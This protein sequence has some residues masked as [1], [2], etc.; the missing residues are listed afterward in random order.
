[1]AVKRFSGSF[2][3]R[4]D[5][6]DNI[7]P[8]N[9]VVTPSGGI[10]VPAGEFKP[11]NWLPVAWQGTASQ[12]YFVI[13]SGKV[14]SLTSQGEVVPSGIRLKAEGLTGGSDTTSTLI[15]YTANDVTA[16]TV[17][18]RTGE[19]VS[20]A[21]AVTLGE[22]ATGLIER[23]LVTA[24]RAK[25]LATT[26]DWV[27]TTEADCINVVK[28]YISDPVGVA[29]YDVYHWAG[30]AYDAE[31]GLNFTNYQKQH[32]VQFFTQA[33]MQM[34]V[35]GLTQR[36]SIDLSGATAYTASAL[37]GT[38]FPTNSG[39]TVLW[40]T[41]T[42][43]NALERY[44]DSSKP[45][46][47]VAAG[48]PIVG[49][50][51]QADGEG[52]RVAAHTSRSPFADANS[53]LA[54][55]K[56]SVADL[57]TNGDY[58]L[59]AHA[60]IVLVYSGWS[61]GTAG[62]SIA[63]M[64][65]TSVSYYYY[66]QVSGASSSWQQVCAVG[67]LEPGDYLT[68][69]E[70][71]NFIKW[72]AGAT[73]RLEGDAAP[74]S[75]AQIM[76][77]IGRVIAVKE[78]PLGLLERVRTAFDGTSFGSSMQMPGSATSGYT[79]LLTLSNE[80][81]ANKVAIINVSFVQEI[82][83]SFKLSDGRVLDLPSNE[84]AAARYLADI[85]LS[86]GH[87]P[88]S[89]EKIDWS[90]FAETISPKNRDLVR[91]SEITPL[92][93][94]ATEIIIREPVE[95]NMVITGMYNRVM[96]QGLNTQILAGAMGAVYAQDIQEHGQYPEVNFQI[97][98]AVSTAWIGKCGIAAAFT[99]EALR[100]STWDI[101]AMNLRLMGQALVRHKEQKAAS[102]LQALG[103]TLFD[104]R[105]P[106]NSLYG[107]TSGMNVSSGELQANG[108]MTMD[109]LMRGFAHMAQEGFTPN[110]LLCHPLQFYSWLQD[111]VLRTM[112]LAHGGGSFFNMYSGDPGP[113]APWSNGAMGGMGPSAGRSI[114]SPTA[115]GT[116]DPTNNTTTGVEGYSQNATSA[117]NVP[118]YFPFNFRVVA[119][120]L[121]PFDVDA[122]LGD[123]FLLSGG[124][125]GFYMVDEEPQTVEWREEAVDAVKVKIRERYGFAVAH[126][127]QGVGVIKNVKAAR[128]YWDGTANLDVSGS[129]LA[130]P[131]AAGTVPPGLQFY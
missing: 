28:V 127:G 64:S 38:A 98:G 12:D 91:S 29:A 35:A 66:D 63:S 55:R 89:D 8:N 33:Q 101:M 86:R 128:N 121:V 41:S 123:V 126:E 26:S 104:N 111:P 25:I 80:T 20:A 115:G 94:K 31:G 43:L 15:T 96:S 1:M 45:S 114:V 23:G 34:P 53:V 30:D 54:N 118:G 68:F 18:I 48:D 83:M 87:L 125:V 74:A 52:S 44:D 78:E 21:G 7:T 85:I 106:A 81:V 103:T 112:M 56:S 77:T 73:S 39:G 6:F 40:L 37:H 16:G 70:F 79:D 108:T 131:P 60:N 95:P 109:D 93:A 2:K 49:F 13:S 50:A 76:R 88:D 105:T 32:L 113:R 92:L 107:V 82:K 120:P 97:G 122:N 22:F 99:D 36:S 90:T 42:Q 51:L 100:Y 19:A 46:M 17:D 62:A 69:D 59:D 84:D 61:G 102:F 75:D 116:L 9:I 5:V 10:A 67:E 14:V 58:F 24:S 130:L 124:N 72:D 119:S 27:A 65:A 71:S 11:A 117:P 110:I 57:H 4:T 129:S 3:T 47:Y